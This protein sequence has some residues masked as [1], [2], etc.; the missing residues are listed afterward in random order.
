MNAFASPPFKAIGTTNRILATDPELLYDAIAIA[1]AEL[2]RLDR[3]ASRFRPDS[4]LSAIHRSAAAGDTVVRLSPCLNAVLAAVLEAA[5]ETGGLVD[6]TV[7]RALIDAGYDRDFAALDPDAAGPARG[8][9]LGWQ[10]LRH[11]RRAGLL[12]L[13]HGTVIDVGAVG[14]AVCADRIAR[15]LS[16][17][18]RGGFLVDLGGDIAIS[19]DP[20]PGGWA[21]AVQGEDGFTRDVVRTSRLALASSSTERRRWRTADG[22][23]RHHILDPR[24]GAPADPVWSLVTCAAP[25]CAAA[26]AAATAAVVLG[27][28]APDWLEERRVAARLERADGIVV[29]TSRWP[30]TTGT[31]C[32][33]LA[34]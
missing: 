30:A 12:A 2:E 23:L 14:K 24:T 15:R 21:V 1:R 33:A 29:A 11:D 18:L 5:S 6:P 26:N 16:Q 31:E 32:E 20:P 17:S 4:E 9:I 13:P 19:G 7:G 28:A 34:A 10:R 3:A 22:E 27:D 8:P 25:T